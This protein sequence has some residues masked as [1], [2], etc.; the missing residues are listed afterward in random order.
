MVQ[1][2]KLTD[3]NSLFIKVELSDGTECLFTGSMKEI[4]DSVGIDCPWYVKS[5]I[6]MIKH[7]YSGSTVSQITAKQASVLMR[8]Q[9][10]SNSKVVVY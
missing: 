7:V 1:L 4:A 5:L 6:E 2:K 3:G 9:S 8:K 10:D